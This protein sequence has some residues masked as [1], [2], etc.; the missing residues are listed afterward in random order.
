MLG[1]NK[2]GLRQ[3]FQVRQNVQVAKAAAASAIAEARTLIAGGEK[4]RPLA[5]LK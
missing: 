3:R 4:S 2:A 1:S 5:S